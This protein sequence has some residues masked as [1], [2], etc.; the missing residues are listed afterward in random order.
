M[1]LLQYLLPLA[2]ATCGFAATLNAA[3]FSTVQEARERSPDAVLD[4]LK[5]KRAVTLAEKGGNLAISGDVQ[6]DWDYMHA[7]RWDNT[8]LR[9]SGSSSRHST[10]K[11]VGTPYATSEFDVEVNLMFDYR[12]D[13]TW[14]AIQFQFD[15]S[16]GI[17]ET[18]TN[19]D[20]G[21]RVKGKKSNILWGSGEYD[22][23]VMRKAYMGINLVDHG[24]SRLD[25]ELGRRRLYDVFDSEVEF[26]N[27][28]DGALLK[29]ANSFEGVTDLTFKAAGF[30][31]D[32]TVNHFGWVGEVG[33]L[34]IGDSGFDFK[35]SLIDWR[36]EG[37]NR[38]DKKHPKGAEFLVNQFL[39]AYTLPADWLRWKTKLYAAF[40]H[41]SDAEKHSFT[42]HEKKAN[43]WY[44]GFKVGDVKR[45]GDWAF[46][47][48][49]EW[50]QAQ[51]VPES[52]VSGIKR[53]NP[54]NLSFYDKRWGGFANYKGYVVDGFYA[55]TDNWTVNV[56]FERAREES[57][58]IGGKHRSYQFEIAAI[59]AF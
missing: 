13:R 12:T 39:A 40:L 53:D 28:F 47:A 18:T 52:D 7:R 1:K 23:I 51:A 41:N 43:A 10:N 50:V 38:Y 45:K 24:T 5:S 6:V 49:Y 8:H 29:Y 59:Y 25:F 15:D 31:V 57:H 58:R 42:H 30:V 55:I 17:K 34:N 21:A 3:D 22:N 11:P 26:Y 46:E 54:Q 48:R 37:H 56:S 36:R 2:M 20:E 44:A 16:M 4:Y 9:G 19:I 33:F 27:F 14:A 35:Y 32:Q